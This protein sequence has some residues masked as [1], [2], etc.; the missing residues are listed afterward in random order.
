MAVYDEYVKTNQ[1][2][3]GEAKTD[4]KTEENA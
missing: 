2:P 4:E 1:G 3:E